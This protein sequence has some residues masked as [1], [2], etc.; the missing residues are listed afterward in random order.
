MGMQAGDAGLLCQSG[1]EQLDG[2]FG[3]RAA[4]F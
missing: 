2:I 3:N 4:I 1:E